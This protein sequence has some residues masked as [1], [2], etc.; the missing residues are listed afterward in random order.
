MSAFVISR[1][2]LSAKVVDFGGRLFF[3]LKVL[4]LICFYLVWTMFWRFPL[5]MLS[6]ACHWATDRT[7]DLVTA[8]QQMKHPRCASQMK[9]GSH[10]ALLDEHGKRVGADV[11]HGGHAHGEEH[12]AHQLSS[13][14]C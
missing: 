13:S 9:D 10:V 6:D 11:E 4:L 5:L 8:V 14:Y 12:G 2:F 1:P 3:C 7:H